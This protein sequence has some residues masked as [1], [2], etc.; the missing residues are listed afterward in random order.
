MENFPDFSSSFKQKID[1][2]LKLNKALIE[3]I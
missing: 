1:F 3:L 2:F